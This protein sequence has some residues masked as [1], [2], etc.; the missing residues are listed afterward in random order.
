ASFSPC[1]RVTAVDPWENLSNSARKFMNRILAVAVFILAFLSANSHGQATTVRQEPSSAPPR[2][3]VSAIPDKSTKLTI[4]TTVI[5]NDLSVKVVPKLA[6]RIEPETGDPVRVSS[7]LGGS[8]TL[9]LLPGRYRVKST[10]GLDFES[11]HFEWDVV[12]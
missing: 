9:D 6:L 11:K 1:S 7:S 10:Q 5:T 8:A 4:R 12:V 2:E 3:G